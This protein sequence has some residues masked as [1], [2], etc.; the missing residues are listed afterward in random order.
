MPIQEAADRS[1]AQL[2]QPLVAQPIQYKSGSPAAHWAPGGAPGGTVL[3]ALAEQSAP[4]PR[5]G[6][7]FVRSYAP[8][9]VGSFAW[10]DLS[11]GRRQGGPLAR[12]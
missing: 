6:G 11:P 7:S 9:T 3:A 12:G 10:S 4:P 5:L 8:P 2:R 1:S